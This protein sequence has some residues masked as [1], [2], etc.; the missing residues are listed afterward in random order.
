MKLH[1]RKDWLQHCPKDLG[2]SKCVFC[3]KIL[4]EPEFILWE[5]EHWLVVYNKYPYLWLK[6]HIMALPKKHFKESHEL[7]REVYSELSQVHIFIKDFFWKQEYFSFTRETFGGR[8][9][10]HL[11]IHFLPW[12]IFADEVE[13]LL[14]RQG[15]RNELDSE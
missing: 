14:E 3:E 11:H 15:F 5:W 1:A 7:T 6:N 12:K 10:E 9:L 2:A 13:W 8:S 4:T